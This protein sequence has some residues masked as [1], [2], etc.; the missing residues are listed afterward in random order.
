MNIGD[1]ESTENLTKRCVNSALAKYY[2]LILAHDVKKRSR[3]Q[4]ARV[5]YSIINAN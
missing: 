5:R 1:G 4:I 2:K 3:S